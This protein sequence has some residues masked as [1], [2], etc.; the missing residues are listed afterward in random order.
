MRSICYRTLPL[1]LKEYVRV[2]VCVCV[3]E[4]ERERERTMRFVLSKVFMNKLASLSRQVMRRNRSHTFIAFV[5]NGKQTL[6]YHT[7]VAVG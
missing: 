1:A 6:R 5:T 4:R 2:Y 3:R 7:T